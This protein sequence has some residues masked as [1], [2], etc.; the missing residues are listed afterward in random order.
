MA[1]K[2]AK[3]RVASQAV[4]KTKCELYRVNLCRIANPPDRLAV[5]IRCRLPGVLD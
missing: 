2:N 1:Q 5:V 3:V 4:K